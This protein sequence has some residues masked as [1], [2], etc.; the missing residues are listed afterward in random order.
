MI[1]SMIMIMIMIKIMTMTMIMTMIMIMS[2][3]MIM[4]MSTSVPLSQLIPR[5]VVHHLLQHK[6]G[7]TTTI[8]CARN[9]IAISFKHKTGRRLRLHESASGGSVASPT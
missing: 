7:S 4:I 1:M 2:M 9:I 3:I 8:G 6:T 5:Y